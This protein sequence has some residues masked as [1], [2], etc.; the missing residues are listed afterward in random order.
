MRWQICALGLAATLGA[1]VTSA[2]QQSVV[3]IHDDDIMIRGCVRPVTPGVPPASMLVWSRGD[4][5]LAGAALATGVSPVGTA[6]MPGQ[7]F[8]WL[9]DDDDLAEH[10]G[11]LVEV[12]GE[13]KDF[14]RGEVEIDR[15]GNDTKIELDLDGRKEKAR[16]PTAWLG[17][18]FRD[19][20][21]DILARRIDVDDV[22]VLGAC[23]LP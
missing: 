8:Y 2:Q 15:E 12:E 14:E 18:G 22:R 23:D 5:M 9:N 21:F 4:L 10:V 19:Q 11:Q 20:E 16:V 7:V 17:P 1:A 3:M 6:G 13:L